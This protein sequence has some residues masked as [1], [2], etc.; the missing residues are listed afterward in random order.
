MLHDHV[1]VLSES[2]AAGD[3]VAIPGSVDAINELREAGVKV[4]F[5][6]NESART[7]DSLCAKLNRLGFSIKAEEVLTPAMAMM[8]IIKQ[9]NLRPHLL[10]HPDVLEDF[11]G[12]DTSEPNCVVIGDCAEH[13]TFNKINEAFQVRSIQI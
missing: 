9:H 8:N 3:G 12:V 2:S 10:V 13:L 5:V 4:K 1:L 6:T 7:R 11:S